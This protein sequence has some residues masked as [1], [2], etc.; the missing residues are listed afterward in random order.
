M[1]FTFTAAPSSRVTKSRM[2]N[3]LL[4]RTSSSPFS[5]VPR[6]K[7]LQR[8]Q[9]KPERG[10]QEEEPCRLD[11]LGLVTSLADGSTPSNPVQSI[12]YIKSRMYDDMPESGG[13]NSTRISEVLNFRRNLP[14]LTTNAHLH[15]LSS[16]STTM[17]REIASLMKK[18]VLRKVNVPG[19][20]VGRSSIGE[21]L[22]LIEDWVLLIK[23]ARL[24]SQIK[25]SFLNEKA[26][27]C[28][29]GH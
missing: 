6:R 20:G 1:P 29:T 26:K 28:L 25:G 22:V 8:A 4:K 10:E 21:V 17:E 16:S 27:A 24:E 11:N 3:P 19:R 13:M 7:P 14:S 18:G 12:N 23:E 9:S 15:A 2:K 5:T